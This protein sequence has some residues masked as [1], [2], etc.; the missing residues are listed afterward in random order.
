[1]FIY[2]CTNFATPFSY[3]KRYTYVDVNLQ[4]FEI[5]TIL[6][7]IKIKSIIVL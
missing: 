7:N 6:Y 1:M 4:C 3:I 2:L 5:R